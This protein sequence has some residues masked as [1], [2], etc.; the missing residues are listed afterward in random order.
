[1]LPGPRPWGQ[2]NKYPKARSLRRASSYSRPG[3]GVH[4]S[5]LLSSS[6]D[7]YG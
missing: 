5:S 6:L 4:V 1:V 3:L 2:R 7:S